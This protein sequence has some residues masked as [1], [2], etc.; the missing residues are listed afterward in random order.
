MNSS[1]LLS[2]I[3]NKRNNKVFVTSEIYVKFAMLY[4]YLQLQCVVQ[5]CSTHQGFLICLVNKI[6]LQ[7]HESEDKFLIFSSPPPF[8]LFLLF[9]QD[10]TV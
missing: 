9:F 4:N 2:G 10:F 5:Q 1:Y 8:F 3:P 6:S 7:K